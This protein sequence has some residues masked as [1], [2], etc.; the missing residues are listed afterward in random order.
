MLWLAAKWAKM[1]GPWPAGHPGNSHL[2]PP[3]PV[4]WREL[5]L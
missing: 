2:L 5:G 3:W 4:E 1:M